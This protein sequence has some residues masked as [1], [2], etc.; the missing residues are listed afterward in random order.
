MKPR[1]AHLRLGSDKRLSFQSSRH[2]ERVFGTR[3]AD[4]VVCNETIRTRICLLAAKQ[5][6]SLESG[7]W[8]RRL[9]QTQL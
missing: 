7:P 4:G 8:G 6:T 9:Q 5:L 3:N 1:V 2:D